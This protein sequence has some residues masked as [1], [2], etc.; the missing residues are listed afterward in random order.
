VYIRGNGR[1]KCQKRTPTGVQ[2]REGESALWHGVDFVVI[3]VRANDTHGVPISEL[4][5]TISHTEGKHCIAS[6]GDAGQNHGVESY[7]GKSVQPN[8]L[9]WT[10]SKCELV[11]RAWN[12]IPVK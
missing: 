3:V 1:T 11:V 8:T 5:S 9:L 12:N 4:D 2:G 10:L 7:I 6:E